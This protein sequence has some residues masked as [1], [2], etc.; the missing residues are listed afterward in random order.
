MLEYRHRLR[1]MARVLICL[2]SFKGSVSSPDA[3]QAISRGW[4][5]VASEDVVEVLAFA[6]G[7]EG[8][9]EALE[10]ALVDSK[11]IKKSLSGA[12]ELS[13]LLM[14]DGSALV[15][16]AE[17][18]G[19]KIE[20]TKN[21]LGATTLKVGQAIKMAVESGSKNIYVALGGSASTDG[22]AGLLIGLGAKLLDSSGKEI[23]GGNRGLASLSSVDLSNLGFLSGVNI[24]VLSDVENPLLGDSGAAR[25]F[26]PQKGASA[27]QLEE[28]E[29]NLQT[30]SD[31]FPDVSPDS[32]GAGA[33]GGTSFG[34]IVLGATIKSGG[35]FVSEITNLDKK[36]ASVDV[37]ITGEGM[38][39]SQSLDG[40]AVSIVL[41]GC[42]KHL[43]P[44]YL[45]A[46]QIVGGTEIFDES[47]SLTDLAP[48]KEISILDPR[49][50]LENAGANLASAFHNPRN[51]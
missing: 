27:F 24:T 29:R 34:L 10:T 4:S 23:E 11:R 22:G 28:M 37:V 48:S 25:V 47:V 30:W 26:G 41:A 39:D 44:C 3:G 13:F 2:D 42:K 15:E 7:G 12:D 38:F 1:D 35:E 6:D 9:I 49:P 19:V 50:W 18:C 46:G 20:G 45:V 5:S 8:T 43:T 33:A 40:K 51:L 31:F 16:L 36:I 17:L 14:P 32:R 21:P